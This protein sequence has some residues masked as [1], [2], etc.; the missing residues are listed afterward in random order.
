M[1]ENVNKNVCVCVCVC[2]YVTESL[3]CA[4]ELSKIL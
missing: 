3:C 2:V 4:A 1:E